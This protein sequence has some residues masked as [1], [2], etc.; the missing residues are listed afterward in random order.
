MRRQFG[1]GDGVIS[2]VNIRAW[3]SKLWLH[4]SWGS[5]VFLKIASACWVVCFDN[6]P[7]LGM[8]VMSCKLWSCPKRPFDPLHRR[9]AAMF[10]SLQWLGAQ[11]SHPS[12]TGFSAESL[13]RQDVF[14][15]QLKEK[16]HGRGFHF[17]RWWPVTG[18]SAR[19]RV[20]LRIIPLLH[21]TVL[22]YCKL[23]THAIYIYTYIYIDRYIDLFIYLFLT[24][25]INMI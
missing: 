25:I 7:R 5:R 13:R 11:Q 15:R 18:S 6:R 2:L 20:R 16:S 24:H 9:K 19:W 1:I 10:F 21:R 4:L 14:P 3:V 8:S 23:M 12:L 17:R 22:T